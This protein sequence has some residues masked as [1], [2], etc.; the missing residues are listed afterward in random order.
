MRALRSVRRPRSAEPTNSE[1]EV[2][3][4]PSAYAVKARYVGRRRLTER[5]LAGAFQIA[6]QEKLIFFSGVKFL[7]IGKEYWIERVDKSFSSSRYPEEV[8][9]SKAA[10]SAELKKW[11]A[12]EFEAEEQVRVFKARVAAS[13]DEE[14]SSIAR[15][16]K[17]YCEGMSYFQVE[18]VIRVLIDKAWRKK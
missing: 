11:V 13:K 15:R 17:D 9:D 7:K 14:L 6:G 16:L 10:D 8:S 18:A 1:E 4:K 3:K 2:V 12:E 5:R